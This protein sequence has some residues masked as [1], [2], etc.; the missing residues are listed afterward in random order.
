MLQ[1]GFKYHMMAEM[2]GLLGFFQNWE[3]LISFHALDT[4]P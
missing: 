3:P 4:I 2:I 1:K